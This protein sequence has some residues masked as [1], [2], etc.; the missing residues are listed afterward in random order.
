MWAQLCLSHLEVIYGVKCTSK[1]A[2]VKEG[3]K[4]LSIS[5]VHPVVSGSSALLSALAQRAEKNL[6][7]KKRE[8]KLTEVQAAWMGFKICQAAAGKGVIT[9]PSS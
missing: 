7:V 9:G 5:A 4:L 3:S 1:G 8:I 6:I 2:G